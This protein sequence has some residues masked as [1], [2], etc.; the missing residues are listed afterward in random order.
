V[1]LLTT[2]LHAPIGAPHASASTIAHRAAVNAV[3]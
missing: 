1:S 2:E 3:R